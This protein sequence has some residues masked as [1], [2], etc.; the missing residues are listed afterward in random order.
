MVSREKEV[1]GP[2]PSL[3]LAG[4]PGGS[5]TFSDLQLPPV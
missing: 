3:P 2:I 4:G 5:P 1:T